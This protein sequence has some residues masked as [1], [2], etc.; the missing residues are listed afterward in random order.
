MIAAFGC[1]PK[2][3]GEKVASNPPSAPAPT[4]EPAKTE[5][6]PKS[7][8]ITTP[9]R[10]PNAPLEAQ[11]L[12]DPYIVGAPVTG[13]VVGYAEGQDLGTLILAICT[14]DE[15]RR[16]QGEGRPP[17]AMETKTVDLDRSDGNR[18]EFTTATE[19]TG[20]LMVFPMDPDS[21]V[22]VLPAEARPRPGG[23]LDNA[24]TVDGVG[25]TGQGAPPD[26]FNPALRGGG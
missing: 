8:S 4:P 1:G 12:L 21:K 10:N 20:G 16:A 7:D 19:S 24:G 22:R 3:A 14:S 11:I 23:P 17:I 5:E 2:A 9:P 15:Y 25:T 13:R 6:P 18:F 26:A